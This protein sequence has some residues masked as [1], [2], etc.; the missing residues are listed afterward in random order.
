LKPQ[1]REL[2][3]AIDLA[4]VNEAIIATG[5]RPWDVDSIVERVLLA[6]DLWLL[7]DLKADKLLVEQEYDLVSK[8]ILDLTLIGTPEGKTAI[9]DWKTT[10]NLKRPNYIEE[11]KSDFQSSLYLAHGGDWL[12]REYGVR[13]DYLEYR[14]LDEAGEFR[15]FRVEARASD[16]EDADTQIWTVKSS[17][18]GLLEEEVWPRNRPRACFIGS[19]AGP[20][21]PY[22]KDCCDM[23]MPKTNLLTTIDGLMDL[24]PRS[25]SSMKSFLECPEKFRRTKLL[26]ATF[27]SS[28]A[29]LAGEAFHAGME[30][31]YKQ[32][33]AL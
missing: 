32:A 15:S 10:G 30:S 12:E 21:C 25:K 19:K 22:Y 16:R 29:I 2:L 14:V 23:T 4:Q 18:D 24:I 13:P 33:I 6:T 20:T 31:I 27:T 1:V 7:D 9:V 28:D 5:I 8:G 11:V 26:G 17:F 3:E